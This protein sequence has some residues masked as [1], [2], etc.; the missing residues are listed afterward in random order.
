MKYLN[1]AMLEKG[2][3]RII[4]TTTQPTIT[5]YS[6]IQAQRLSWPPHQNNVGPFRHDDSACRSQR[7]TGIQLSKGSGSIYLSRNLLSLDVGVCDVF[8]SK[9][10]K[11]RRFIRSGYS[12]GRRDMPRLLRY[13]V[14]LAPRVNC[15]DLS[16]VCFDDQLSAFLVPDSSVIQLVEEL[17]QLAVPQEG[18]ECPSSV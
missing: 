5:R 11:H 7:S 17:T 9:K 13:V 12:V 16:S 6:G 8:C 1:R 3:P 10:Y 15:P 2:L 18:V 4:G 14:V